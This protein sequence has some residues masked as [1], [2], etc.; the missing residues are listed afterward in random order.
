LKDAPDITKLD[1]NNIQTVQNAINYFDRYESGW[2]HQPNSQQE[3]TSSSTTVHYPCL[4]YTQNI[5]QSKPFVDYNE[6][7]NY[8]EH[9]TKC[10]LQTCLRKVGHD[11]E[12]C[13]KAPW[14]LQ[15]TFTLEIDENGQPK[16]THACNDNILNL[17]NLAMLSIWRANVDCKVVISI[18]VVLKYISK[19]ATKAKNKSK[20]YHSM[21]S[22]ISTIYEPQQ[23]VTDG[24]QKMLVDNIVDRDISARE[25]SHLMQKLPLAICS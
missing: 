3:Q 6:L 24:F 25:A 21:L 23:P 5:L 13:Y 8:V 7:V 2:N 16:H 9:H 14:N 22:C 12:C 19:Y 15:Q 10:T 18:D 4:L 1:W 17:H 20:T 11:V